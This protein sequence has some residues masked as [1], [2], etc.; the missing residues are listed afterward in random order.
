MVMLWIEPI[1]EI[2]LVA[3]VVLLAA[4]LLTGPVAGLALGWRHG[5][6]GRLAGSALGL[7]VGVLSVMVV[8]VMMY[9]ADQ[10]E[11]VLIGPAADQAE[12]VLIGPA[13]DQAEMVLIGP[14]AFAEAGDL[15]PVAI[16]GEVRY[17]LP[18][19]GT[20]VTGAHHGPLYGRMTLTW[21]LLYPIRV[22]AAILCTWF[23]TTLLWSLGRMGARFVVRSR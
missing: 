15:A 5:R 2:K 10:A 16:G 14:A 19:S 11:M 21:A 6:L 12:M 4:A 17:A 13:A 23:A 18:V 3:L 20:E 1:N 9:E 8:A 7:G 22:G